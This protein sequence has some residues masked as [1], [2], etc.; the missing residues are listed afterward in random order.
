MFQIVKNRVKILKTGDKRKPSEIFLFII[1]CIRVCGIPIVGDYFDEKWHWNWKVNHLL[2]LISFTGICYIFNGY[3]NRNDLRDV[4][5]SICLGLYD[6]MSLQRILNFVGDQGKIVVIVKEIEDFLK[7][8]EKSAKAYQTLMWYFQLIEK[9]ILTGSICIILAGFTIGFG[10]ILIYFIFGRLQLVYV[11]FIPYVDYT[12]H[13]GFEIH[14]LLHGWISSFFCLGLALSAGFLFILLA[15]VGI[16]IDILN[17]RLSTLSEEMLDNKT[18][19]VKH[20]QELKS[21]Y[22]DHQ[23]LLRFMVTVEEM[24]AIQELFDHVILG[25]QM[26]LS[27]FVCFQEFWF[28]CCFVML[29]DTIILLVLDLL[30]TI[31]DMKFEKLSMAVWSLPWYLMKLENQKDYLYFL[32]NTQ[33]TCWLTV[34]GFVPLSLNTFVRLYKGIYSYCMVL[35]ETQT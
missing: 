11:C 24:I 1:E 8:W 14:V 35:V 18:P 3:E 19:T 12:Q 22:H 4:C 7:T 6:I 17:I 15:M 21:I 34:G 33:K 5:F 16:Q 23:N 27:L 9:C 29:I 30:G 26:C 2:G 10:P 28:P 13:P 20:E 31:I 25:A 32:A